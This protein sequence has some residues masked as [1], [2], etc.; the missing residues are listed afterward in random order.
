MQGTKTWK[1]IGIFA[2]PSRSSPGTVLQGKYSW[3]ATLLRPHCHQYNP[4]H[5]DGFTLVFTFPYEIFSLFLPLPFSLSIFS[6]FS[7]FLFLFPFPLL[8][9]LFPLLSFPPFLPSNIRQLMLLRHQKTRQNTFHLLFSLSESQPLHC[10]TLTM[11]SP[12]NSPRR[13]RSSPGFF[14]SLISL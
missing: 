5:S 11:P 1:W 8:F 6:S 10:H 7:L 9:S 3:A 12:G 14:S 13:C 2:N 4:Q